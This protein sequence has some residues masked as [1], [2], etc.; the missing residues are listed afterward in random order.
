MNVIPVTFSMKCYIGSTIFPAFFLE[1]T[2]Q[3]GNVVLVLKGVT[4]ELVFIFGS[5]GR[6]AAGGGVQQ[7][8]VCSRGR[9]AGGALH[10]Y[11]LDPSI[12]GLCDLGQLL[13]TS[14]LNFLL[15]RFKCDLDKNHV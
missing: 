14:Y 4:K 1:K 3:T 7:G 9:F 11:H 10:R 13:K 12:P 6:C 8:E 2:T 5:R 15:H